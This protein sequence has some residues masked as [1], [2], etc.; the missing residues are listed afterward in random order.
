MDI[1]K[2]RS[3][4]SLVVASLRSHCARIEIAGSIRRGK[5]Q[6][7]DIEIVCEPLCTT[8]NDLF[9]S[10]IVINPLENY[11]WSEMG[12]MLLNG[13]RQKK[14]A[15]EQGIDLDLFI[16]LPPAQWG[17]VYTIRTGPADFSKWI[18]TPRQKSGALPSLARVTN[19]AVCI[20]GK[21]LPM[22]EEID[23]LN[24]LDLGW[25]EPS[26]RQPQWRR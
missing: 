24:F 3:L 13:P 19:G 2:A 26:Q 15:L 20:S 16:V 10:P 25:I 4:A 8:Q 14:I 5:P 12:R 21:P 22:P 23:F 17:V 6:V 9:G 1:E 18:V 7:K 11:P